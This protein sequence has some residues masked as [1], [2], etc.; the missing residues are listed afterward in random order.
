MNDYRWADLS[1]GLSSR[2]D[3]VVDS[4]M[5][6]AFGAVSGDENPLHCDAEFA[7][8]SGFPGVVVFGML[9]SSFY[10]RL[11]GMYLPGKWALLHGIEIDFKAPVFVGDV[12]TVTGEIAL[13]NDAYKRLEIK[14]RIV[15]QAEKPVS[16]ATIRVGVREP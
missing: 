14:A 3:V 7:R 4:D 10:S 8:K 11:V 12:L 5:M 2:F 16:R 6:K 1:L 13:L 15:N 9:S